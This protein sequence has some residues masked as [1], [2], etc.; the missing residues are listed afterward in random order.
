MH[1]LSID[2][3]IKILKTDIESGLTDKEVKI[4]SKKGKNEIDKKKKDSIIVKF[5]KQFKDALILILLGA[6][7]LSVVVNKDEWIDSVVTII[8]TS[9]RW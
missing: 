5:I 1:S 7:I 9:Y 6:A 8:V 4:R 2:E 3:L